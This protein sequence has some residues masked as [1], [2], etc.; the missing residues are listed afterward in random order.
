MFS[1]YYCTF[2]FHFS[3]VENVHNEPALTH[4]QNCGKV[5]AVCTKKAKYKITYV[6]LERIK[7]YFIKNFVIQD[8]FLPHVFDFAKIVPEYLCSTQ[9]K[10]NRICNCHMCNIARLCGTKIPQRKKGRPLTYLGVKAKS[11]ISTIC[12]CTSYKSPVRSGLSHKCNVTSLQENIFHIFNNADERTQ[13]I[14]PSK[15]VKKKS[16]EGK[17]VIK[18]AQVDTIIASAIV[19][20]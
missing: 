5:C 17:N 19:E 10:P 14:I 12:L 4:D 13:E 11:S 1:Y 6:V 20:R 18:L 3:S 8:A 9:R 16:R 15:V 2:Y 7:S